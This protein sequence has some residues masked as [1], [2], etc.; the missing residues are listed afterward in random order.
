MIFDKDYTRLM[1]KAR[2]LVPEAD[3]LRWHNPQPGS[4]HSFHIERFAPDWFFVRNSRAELYY[5]CNLASLLV[6][7]QN[8]LRQ[9]ELVADYAER[10]ERLAAS[11]ELTLLSQSEI[12]DLFSDL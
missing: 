9:R 4:Y 3:M 12:D 6:L 10:Q 2:E 5:V 7:L 8:E 1:A 11:R